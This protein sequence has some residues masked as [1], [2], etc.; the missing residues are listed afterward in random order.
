MKPLHADPTRRL[1]LQALAALVGGS[2][3]PAAFAAP[4]YPSRPIR[5]VVPF[6]PGGT[7]DVVAR[8]LTPAWGELLGQPIVVDNRSGAGGMTGADNVAK[9]PPDGYTLLAFHVG[10]T[11]GSALFK[12]LPYDVKRDFQP[13]GLLGATPS[14]LVVNNK[15][16]VRS[17]GELLAL[18]KKD[19][20]ALNYAS[21]GIGA[22]SH[23][24]V[25]LLQVVTGA[26][27]THVPFR[28]GAPAVTATMGGDTQMMVET[29]ASV[30][31]HIKAGKLRALAVTGESRLA[32][33][34]E[35]PTMKEAGVADYVYTTWFGLWAPAATP[36]AIVQKL[37][38]ATQAA[39]DKPATR[40]GLARA[41]VEVRHASTAEFEKLVHADVDK[42]S[43]IIK[44]AGIEPE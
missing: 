6:A 15:S 13:V 2:A 21:A 32:D 27:F 42:W 37:H 9:S 41:G 36:A 4:D 10:L 29:S 43:Q 44:S 14:I 25:E 33:L 5:V 11:Y 16:P 23:L 31:P 12:K 18:A 35:V 3:L 24:A 19:P 8:M 30:L 39:L 40:Q 34:P 20:G 38:Q 17:V 26:R 22:S 1:A 28:G 7:V